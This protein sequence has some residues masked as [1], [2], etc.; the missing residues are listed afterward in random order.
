MKTVTVLSSVCLSATTVLATVCCVESVCYFLEGP[1]HPSVRRRGQ[2]TVDLGIINELYV[3]LDFRTASP[4]PVARL[5]KSAASISTKRYVGPGC[6]KWLKF[7]ARGRRK[8]QCLF[9]VLGTAHVMFACLSEIASWGIY[10]EGRKMM[11]G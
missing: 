11:L 7:G 3:T 6:C 10:S 2:R 1:G 9:A 4:R 5:G 8:M